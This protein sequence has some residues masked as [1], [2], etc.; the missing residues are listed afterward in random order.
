MS[1]FESYLERYM[2]TYRLPR[3]EVL[4]LAVV[5]EVKRYYESREGGTQCE[6]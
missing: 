5:R 2:Q 4:Q 1:D 6:P 3:D